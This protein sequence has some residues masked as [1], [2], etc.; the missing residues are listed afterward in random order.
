MT[1]EQINYFQ[2]KFYEYMQ[3]YGALYP[4]DT[5]DYII[6]HLFDDNFDKNIYVDVMSQVYETIGV[7]DV[8]HDT[9]YE[10]FY[11]LLKDNY[12]LDRNLLEVGCGYFPSF[13]NKVSENQKKGSI[14][15]MDPDVIVQKLGKL[16]IIKSRF[17][18]DT[19]VSKYELIY[20]LFPCDATIDMIR[21]ANEFDKDLCIELCGCVHTSD[22][23]MISYDSWLYRVEHIL[24]STIPDNREFT[25][26]EKDNLPYPLI[27]TYRK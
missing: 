11:N 26:E 25:M 15:V 19:D 13:A 10:N 27:K 23:L 5:R 6:E 1:I 9:V 2:K 16:K 14:T 3:K 17:N 4:V 7:F 12:N 22:P 24:K 8:V 18:K 21:S 20:G